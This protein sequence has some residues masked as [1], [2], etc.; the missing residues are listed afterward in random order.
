MKL[1]IR[2][3][4]H[5]R[6]VQKEPD[7]ACGAGLLR[8]EVCIHSVYRGQIHRMDRR[9]DCSQEVRLKNNGDLVM[10]RA[11]L[12]GDRTGIFRLRVMSLSKYDGKR[13]R[14][15]AVAAE[16]P[17]RPPESMPPERKTPTGTSLTSCMRSNT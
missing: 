7:F 16:M 2:R 6:P 1:E 13:A 10:V 3:T 5:R 9:R 11:K 8:D 4:P 15:Y 14:S 12:L 17:T